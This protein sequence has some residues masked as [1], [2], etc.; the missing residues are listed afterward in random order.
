MK[1]PKKFYV[2]RLYECMSKNFTYSN[3]GVRYHHT[4]GYYERG[5]I[6]GILFRLSKYDE[7]YDNDCER[8]DS[9]QKY[10]VALVFPDGTREL[11]T[12]ESSERNAWRELSPEEEMMYKVDYDMSQLWKSKKEYR[13]IAS[14]I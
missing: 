3:N 4:F 6:I 9:K 11:G 5:T 13:T 8:F 12:V 7:P 1:K 10:N 2:K 14:G